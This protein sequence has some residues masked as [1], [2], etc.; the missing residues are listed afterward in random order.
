MVKIK[1]L[2]TEASITFD[3]NMRRDENDDDDEKHDNNTVRHLVLQ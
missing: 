1:K 2:N 3:I